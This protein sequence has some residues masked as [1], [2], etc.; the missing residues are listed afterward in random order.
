MLRPCRANARLSILRASAGPVLA[1]AWL[2]L[3]APTGLFAQDVPAVVQ[4]STPILQSIVITGAKELPEQ[5]VLD[6]IGVAAGQ[7]LIE[8]PDHIS[9]TIQRRYRNEGYTF[10]RVDT[11]FDAASGALSV[12][13]DEGVIDGVEFQGVDEQLVRKFSAEFA[14]RA[15]DWSPPLSAMRR[16]STGRI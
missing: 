12:A 7:P 5:A 16:A 1:G 6:T 15:G 13:I 14:L 2:C 8:T 4:P 11:Q 3:S 9:E 10:A